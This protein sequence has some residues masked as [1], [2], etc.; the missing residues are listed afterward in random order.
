MKK[1]IIIT[2]PCYI[3]R[4][5][6]YDKICSLFDL[7]RKAAFDIGFKVNL[8]LINPFETLVF[9]FESKHDKTKEKIIFHS[10]NDTPNGDGSY[11]F[12]GQEIGVDSGMLCIA[13]CENDWENEDFGATFE[14]INEAKHVFLDVLNKF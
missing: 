12:A 7:W 6:D 11:I 13:E 14:T 9:P 3:M 4:E 8:N 10:I 2:D 1:R 5:K